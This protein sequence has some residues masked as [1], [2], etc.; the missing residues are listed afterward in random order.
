[1]ER[2]CRDIL[3]MDYNIRSIIVENIFV[4]GVIPAY[5]YVYSLASGEMEIPRHR[6][7]HFC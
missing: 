2:L 4:N 3:T 5:I 6:S 1:M 7:K